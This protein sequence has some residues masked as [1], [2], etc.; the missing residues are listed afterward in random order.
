MKKIIFLITLFI[1][2]CLSG[3][4]S[5]FSNITIESGNKID[6]SKRNLIIEGKT[7][8]SEVISLLGEPSLKNVTDDGYLMFL[9]H[10]H[11]HKIGGQFQN[12]MYRI[13]FDKN[14]VVTSWPK[15]R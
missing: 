11:K 9:Y 10:Y 6:Q 12:E 4:L 3:I 15:K 13:Y 1:L 5:C 7:T 14:G 2:F 8:K